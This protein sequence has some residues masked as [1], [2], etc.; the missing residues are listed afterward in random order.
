MRKRI[1]ASVLCCIFVL[2]LCA[3]GGKTDAADVGQSEG[4][5]EESGYTQGNSE[6]DL[7]QIQ[8]ICK[9]ATLECHYHNVAKLHKEKGT[10]LSH[11]GEKDRTLWIE[12]TGVARIGIDM[13]KV[14]LSMDGADVHITIPGGE[15]IGE[16]E[17]ALI[18]QN[19]YIS[20]DD[21]WFNKNPITAE[22]QTQAVD[23]A[24]ENMK[25]SIENNTALLEQAQ[26]R[27][28]KLIENYVDRIGALAGTEYN[29]IWEES[30]EK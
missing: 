26:A 5:Q 22:E 19:S 16:C 10:G 4:Q 6:P 29:I 27:A 28:K 23:E 15:I 14:K 24:Q 9:L 8:S 3:C 17:V 18:D 30:A 25:V 13:S 21:S 20:S 12:Y 7:S 2:L 11:I 1:S